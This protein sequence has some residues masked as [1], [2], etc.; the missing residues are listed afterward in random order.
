MRNVFLFSI[1]FCAIALPT[2]GDLTDTDLNK[3]RL[4]INEEIEE[5]IKP[6]K[7]EIVTLQTDVAWIKGK[8]ES[9]DKQFESIDKQFDSVDK[10]FDSVDKQFDRV[11]DQFNGVREQITH[12]TNITYG[13]IALIVAAIAVPQMLIAWRSRQDNVSE[14][15]VEMLIQEME[16]L[17]QQ[18]ETLKQEEIVNP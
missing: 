2:L 5:A 8:L 9:V 10:Q 14:K 13:L 1:F 4:I 12:A 16:T 17:K 11:D 15:R 3:I 18:M 7:A 6:I